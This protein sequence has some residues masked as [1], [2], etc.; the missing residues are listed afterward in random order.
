MK[1][2]DQKCK[3]TINAN[4]GMCSECNTFIRLT[5]EFKTI[6]NLNTTPEKTSLKQRDL[7]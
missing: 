6:S 3:G 5:K 1:C 2:L 4:T 7:R